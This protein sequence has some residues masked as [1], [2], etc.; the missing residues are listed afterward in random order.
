MLVWD[1]HFSFSWLKISGADFFSKAKLSFST[2]GPNDFFPIYVLW[3]GKKINSQKCVPY[4]LQRQGLP[5]EL[6]AAVSLLLLLS[7]RRLSQFYF[8]HA[9]P[10]R[11]PRGAAGSAG[12][13]FAPGMC[14]AG[15][16]LHFISVSQLRGGL[17]VSV[18]NEL[19]VGYVLN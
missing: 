19:I 18:A 4:W 16:V 14:E 12:C 7:E 8:S 17:Q 13:P 5:H 6:K 9:E 15:A 11:A 2:L 10:P 1:H 3:E